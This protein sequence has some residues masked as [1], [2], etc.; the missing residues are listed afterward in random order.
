M[1]PGSK[2]AACSMVQRLQHAWQAWQ[3][4]LSG[5]SIL[6]PL[7]H[8]ASISVSAIVIVP[9]CTGVL[10]GV[11][12]CQRQRAAPAQSSGAQPLSSVGVRAHRTVSA[13]VLASN[14]RLVSTSVLAGISSY[15]CQCACRCYRAHSLCQT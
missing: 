3:A 7:T 9:M 15:H 4:V 11:S 1:Q 8:M 10:A 14:S 5:T 13:S 12:F 2:A 6:V